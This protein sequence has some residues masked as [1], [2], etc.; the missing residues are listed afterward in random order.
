MIIEN[1]KNEEILKE[2][3]LSNISKLINSKKLQLNYIWSN[4]ITQE[5]LNTPKQLED[6]QQNNLLASN[7]FNSMIKFANHVN[8]IFENIFLCDNDANLSDEK[9]MSILVTTSAII[10]KMKNFCEI[11]TRIF[12]KEKSIAD[13][14]LKLQEYFG[15]FK[16]NIKFSDLCKKI[17]EIYNYLSDFNQMLISDGHLK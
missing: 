11:K 3:A 7:I 5:D 9:V 6:Q 14:L 16:S 17:E 12:K 15:L 2:K 8:S 4:K 10:Q 1:E 13:P